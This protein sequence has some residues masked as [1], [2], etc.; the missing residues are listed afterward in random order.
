MF[1]ALAIHTLRCEKAR[2]AAT[3]RKT[4][5]LSVSNQ[6]SYQLSRGRVRAPKPA[7]SS[8]RLKAI[9]KIHR[10][11]LCLLRDIVTLKTLKKVSH[12]LLISKGLTRGQSS[13]LTTRLSSKHRAQRLKKSKK[14]TWMKQKSPQLPLQSL[15]AATTLVIESKPGTAAYEQG[16]ET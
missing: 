4:V 7:K 11:S 16:S 14:Q 5:F 2:L 12:L 13:S 1:R 6:T 10:L 3:N 8:L 9:R 15:S